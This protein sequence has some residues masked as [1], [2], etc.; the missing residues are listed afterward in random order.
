V[1]KR[2]VMILAAVGV[3]LLAALAVGVLTVLAQEPE[4]AM[5]PTEPDSA[6]SVGLPAQLHRRQD[7]TAMPLSAIPVP[8]APHM[9][10]PYAIDAEIATGVTSGDPLADPHAGISRGHGALLPADL[11][12]EAAPAFFAGRWT[13][14]AH[15]GPGDARY[16]SESDDLHALLTEAV[17]RWPELSGDAKL[18]RIRL[19]VGE[20]CRQPDE[21]ADELWAYVTAAATAERGR[22]DAVDRA[23]REVQRV[24]DNRD[25]ARTLAYC[26]V[27][28]E[29][30]ADSPNLPRVHLYA[31]RAHARAR[32][33]E[34]AK[35]A[36]HLA[37][38]GADGRVALDAWKGQLVLAQRFQWYQDVLVAAEAMLTH[39]EADD[40]DRAWA[41][42][43]R[44]QGRFGLDDPVGGMADCREAMERFPNTLHARHAERLA[45]HKRAA[46]LQELVSP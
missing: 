8:P 19:H 28:A 30:V 31:A 10:E 6:G 42:Y 45:T 39:A 29:R 13:D 25:D 43:A 46:T 12:A 23:L 18:Q 37:A 22:G 11:T 16:R 20:R 2:P 35:A 27:V 40:D 33:Y 41:L 4:R 38:A 44:A 24:F 34:A 9:V 21:L 5:E 1:S 7:L 14:I 17:T 15:H 32:D 26:Q 36:Y 3:T